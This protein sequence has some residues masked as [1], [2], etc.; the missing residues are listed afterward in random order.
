MKDMKI[1]HFGIIFALI[2]LFLTCVN[3][4]NAKITDG[5]VS[6]WPFDGNLK[7][8]VGNNDG[9]FFDGNSK[10]KGETGPT[11]PK[12]GIVS[13]WN[14]DG[15]LDDDADGND[16][17][18]KGAPAKNDPV[19]VNGKFGKAILFD[20]IDDYIEIPDN[21]SLHLPE[22]LTVTAWINFTVG[23]DHAAICWKGKMIGWGAYYSWRVCTTSNTGMTWGRCREG[24]EDYFA[25]DNVLSGPNQWIHVAL[26]CM[27]PDA[28][29]PQRVYVNGK[30]VTDVTGQ[31]GSIKAVPP[32]LVFEGMPVEIGVAR[33]YNGEAGNDVFFSGIIDD[34]GIWDRGLTEDEIKEVMT[35]G[36]PSA[37]SVDANGKIATTWGNLKK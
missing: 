30:D 25:T 6:A 2:Y 13:A 26:T 3:I 15:D 10:P 28:P 8:S 27:S 5:L 19:Y 34:V 18:F 20:G 1:L 32:F 23:R 9:E 12:K 24:T 29:T 7:D 33:G 35:K 31:P 22:D 14:F 36:L 21:K 16:G 17:E 37:Y 4:V 11:D